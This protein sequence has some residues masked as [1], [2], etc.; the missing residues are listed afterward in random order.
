MRRED[1]DRR[2]EQLHRNAGRISANLVEL[3][4]DPSRQRV[5]ASTLEGETAAR[6]A[7]ANGALIELWRRHELLEDLLG[8]ADKLHSSR[9]ADELRWLLD[10]RSIELATYEIPLEER[11][12]LSR[13]QAARR[14]SVEELLASMSAPF[15][16][17][18]TVISRIDQAWGAMT[19][20]LEDG[21]RLLQEA[22]RLA[23][24]L[25]EPRP[26]ELESASKTLGALSE[27]I[28]KDPL[29]VDAKDVDRLVRAVEGV[30]DDLES[31]AGLKRGF[32][33]RIR[34]A[35]ELL[36]QLH[37]EVVEAQSARAEVMVKIR[38][39]QVP[40][41]PEGGRDLEHEL[42]SIA[43]FGRHGAWTE[44]RRAL[45]QWRARVDALRASAR[46]TLASSRAPIE[47]RNQ[48]RALLDAYQVK[49]KR[50]GLVEEPQLAGVFARA[51]ETLYRAPTD[52]ALAAELVRSYQQAL[53]GTESDA[54]AM[55]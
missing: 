47:T 5:E 46:R 37:A 25:A 52:L 31:T 14:C 16:Q 50:L 2:L 24:E 8:R 35:R 18:K 44:A 4:I 17:I 30:R 45:A 55:R 39:P 1:L 42:D 51:Q 38:E 12:L 34:E 48:F 29:S 49:A 13:S 20:K 40:P 32:E 43:E 11:D 15:D 3:E 53:S 26:P 9:Q 33:V 28:A 22:R 7:A 21:R 41:A 54:E 6:R 27:S 23:D 19:P 10:E 36:A